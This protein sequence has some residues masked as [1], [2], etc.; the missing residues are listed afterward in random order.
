MTTAAQPLSDNQIFLKYAA[1]RPIA[2]YGTLPLSASGGNAANVTWQSQ[3]PETPVWVDSVDFLVS[4]KLN[5]T[6]PATQAFTLSPFAPYSAF[7]QNFTIAGAPPWPLQEMTPFLFDNMTA[8]RDWDPGYDGLGQDAGYI[9]G[10]V[11]R[12]PYAQSFDAASVAPG[13]TYTNSGSTSATVTLT[14]TFPL[15]V[16]LQRKRTDMWGMVPLGDPKNRLATNVQL[17]PIV[18]VNPESN[19][20]VSAGA[21]VTAALDG[22]TQSFVVANYNVRDIDILP[23][24]IPT[25]NPTVGRGLT[26]NATSISMTA[27]GTIK[28]FQH[29][30]AMI[31]TAL[32]HILVNNQ[33]PIRPDYMGLWL[34]QEQK[35]ARHDFDNQA[36]TLDAYFRKFFKFYRRY[37]MTGQYTED[38]AR[39]SFPDLPAV[40]PYEA[41][42]SPDSTYADQAGV[43]ATPSMQTALRIAAG[44]ALTDAY[45]R[46]YEVGLVDVGY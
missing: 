24:G 28:P 32:H 15:H 18:G 36:N 5:V 29:I 44:T 26:I 22:T 1:E 4:W 9:S 21:G 8:T 20:I 46:I 17:N 37:P 16:Q 13:K 33:S 6:V 42:M 2:I 38:F 11:D 34:T 12:G 7:S 41:L 23:N 30:D 43:K 25:P 35:S 40:D 45:A 14:W 39:G 31:Y 10:L 3:P 19:L 27:A